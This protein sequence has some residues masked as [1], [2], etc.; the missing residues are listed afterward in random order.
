MAKRKPLTDASGEVRE[1]TSADF[2][3]AKPFSGLPK[4]LQAKLRKV[5]QRGP[6][7]APTKKLVSLR[8]S[9]NVL[10]HYKATGRGWQTR[11]DE[12]LK[13]AVGRGRRGKSAARADGER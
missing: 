9:A 2:A 12:T 8:L 13:R 5:G 10:A 6:Q 3:H 7:I 4:R 11:I 1:L